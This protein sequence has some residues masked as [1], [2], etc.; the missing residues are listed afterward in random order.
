MAF[1]WACSIAGRTTLVTAVAP[2]AV[3]QN[4][5]GATRTACRIVG[6]LIDEKARAG[7][8]TRSEPGSSY[9]PVQQLIV[10]EDEPSWPAE[11][12]LGTS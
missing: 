3:E 11:F 12:P 7:G 9:Y 10:V 2:H 8:S 5:P 4:Q 1:E 6:V